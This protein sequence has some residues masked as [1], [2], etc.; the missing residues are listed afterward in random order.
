MIIIYIVTPGNGLT[1]REF[2]SVENSRME[3]GSAPCWLLI[4]L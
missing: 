1:I 3:E 2:T 4:K